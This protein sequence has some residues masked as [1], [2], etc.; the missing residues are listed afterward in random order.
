MSWERR[1]SG[2]ERLSAAIEI[3]CAHPPSIVEGDAVKMLPELIARA[4]ADAT[5]CVYGTHT[6]YQFPRET[7]I[8]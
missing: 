6:L 2:Q 8:G 5:L 3:A 1:V 4:P 7:L